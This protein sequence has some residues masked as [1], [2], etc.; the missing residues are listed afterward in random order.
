[1]NSQCQTATISYLLAITLL[2]LIWV[3]PFYIFSISHNPSLDNSNKLLPVC[4]E[5][6][7]RLMAE[8]MNSI[9]ERINRIRGELTLPVKHIPLVRSV[10]NVTVDVT[11]R[12]IPGSFG[13]ALTPVATRTLSSCENCSE[14]FRAFRNIPECFGLDSDHA[15]HYWKPYLSKLSKIG[16]RILE[17][18]GIFRKGIWTQNFYHYAPYIF[19]PLLTSIV[20][21]TRSTSINHKAPHHKNSF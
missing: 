14:C 16:W 4:L 17:Y 1:V 15:R 21:S 19:Y 6:I 5:N 8:L 7:C 2:G 9:S 11:F 18:P 3:Q 20:T 12:N 13:L 10:K